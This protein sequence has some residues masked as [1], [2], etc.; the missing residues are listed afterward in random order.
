MSVIKLPNNLLELTRVQQEKQ[1]TDLYIAVGKDYDNI[2]KMLGRLRG[3]ER[4]DA[5]YL[6]GKREKKK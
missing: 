3:G 2:F 1:L 5:D 6:A 4:I